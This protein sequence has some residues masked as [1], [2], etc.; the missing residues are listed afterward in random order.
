MFKIGEL[1]LQ[2]LQN[3]CI[4]FI[5]GAKI[6]DH[7]TPLYRELNILKIVERRMIAIAVLA[8]KIIK[9]KKP[10]YLYDR[11][12]FTAESNTR[13]TRS[14][15]MMIQIPS[16]RLEKYHKSFHVQ[17][18]KVW[19]DYKLFDCIHLSLPTFRKLMYDKWLNN[20]YL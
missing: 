13:N 12:T 3:A 17:S 7:V 18:A 19:N 20:M 1:K 4:R 5:T 14:S 2:K 11:Y 16:H 6:Y 9:W 10:S 8:F 15:R